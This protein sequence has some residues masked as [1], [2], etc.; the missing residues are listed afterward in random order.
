[1]NR[2]R[3]PAR[4]V[5]AIAVIVALVAGCGSKNEGTES[6]QPGSAR[7]AASLGIGDPAPDFRL[8]RLD[9]TPLQLSDLR[10]K[11]VLID[12]WATWCPPCRF[13]LPHLQELNADFGDRLVVVGIA[14]DREGKQVVEPFVAKNGIDFE[15]VLPDAHVIDAYGGISSIPTSFLVDPAGRIAGKWIGLTSKATLA[16][17][18]SAA[19]AS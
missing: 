14:L 4:L 19:L 7:S 16:N 1:M 3:H 15:I 13:A 10:G 11:A 8:Q 9:G 12:F 5:F 6:E 17:A 18:V 2:H